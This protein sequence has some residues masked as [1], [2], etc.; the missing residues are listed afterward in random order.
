M[1]VQAAIEQYLKYIAGTRRLSSS[2][3]EVYGNC[4]CNLQRFLEGQHITDL[5]EVTVS[6]VRQWQLYI[7]KDLHYQATTVKKNLSVLCGWFRYLRR[8]KIVN[9]DIMGHITAPRTPRHLPVFFRENETAKI[10]DRNQFP[11]G[12]TGERDQLLLRLL[13]ETGMRR[14]EL[15]ELCE[16]SVDFS[17]S[18]IKVRGKRDKERIIPIETE[19]SR[20]IRE[21]LTLKREREGK[22]VAVGKRRI[23]VHCSDSLLVRD[24]GKTADVGFIYHTVRHYMDRF[25]HA[26]RRSP[27]VFRHSFATQ[28]LNEGADLEAIKELLGHADLSTTEIYTHVTREHLKDTYNHAHP[29]ALKKGGNT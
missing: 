25:S 2:T 7:V 4:L 16:N 15:A 11:V 19:L 6:V 24:N 9:E 1:L 12:F 17:S 10:Y 27:H 5:E 26:K 29:R 18:T 22:E 28:M 14:A 21:Y 8:E 3:Q 13:Y 20:N 23:T